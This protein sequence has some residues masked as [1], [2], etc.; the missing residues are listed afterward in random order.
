MQPINQEIAA[1][2]RLLTLPQD[3]FTTAYIT[4]A[5]AMPLHEHTAASRALVP[6]LL[7]KRC[8]RYPDM[9]DLNR[10]LYELYGAQV[11]GL[12]IGAGDT[13]VMAMT[14]GMIRD[15]CALKGE[16]PVSD[17]VAV[18]RELLFRP[19]LENGLFSEEDM[20]TEKRCMV[21]RI[22][23]EI[24]EKRRYA[25]RRTEQLLCEGEACAVPVYGTEEQVKALDAEQV[26]AA[27]QNMLRTAQVQII[28]QG[29]D[30]VETVV[31][32]LMQEFSAVDRAPIARAEKKALRA[33]AC[34]RETEEM[35]LNQCKLVMGLYGE[36]TPT[37]PRVPAIRLMNAVLG[38]TAHS[39][40]F[41]HVREEQS[42][43]YYCSSSFNRHKG[44]MLI[45]S[46]VETAMVEKAETEILKQLTA[47]Q[48]GDFSEEELES[49]KRSLAT[50]YDMTE[51]G[52]EELSGWYLGQTMGADTVQ[53]PT[54][55]AA[56]LWP[57][58][59]AD[60]QAAARLFTVGCVYL[61]KPNGEGEPA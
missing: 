34:R 14:A 39:L 18:L 47:V 1:G 33:R 23:A 2:I 9:S 27:W 54:E 55:A 51:D 3:R 32:D 24:N 8:A 40:L 10:R 50:H 30:D 13:Q 26:T 6:F 31:R 43:C 16:T 29:V 21:E 22:R 28:V 4:V 60:V 42:L 36:I 52:Q 15:N 46:G 48:N 41:K 44:I 38:G 20:Q 56:E 57:L 61:L 35:E 25:R 58:T 12:V 37:D 53:T 49:A 59:K 7:R 17:T 11:D 45:D 5:F 19:L